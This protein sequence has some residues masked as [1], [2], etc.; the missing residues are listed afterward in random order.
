MASLLDLHWSELSDGTFSSAAASG[1]D[2]ETGGVAVSAVAEAM[3]REFVG[4]VSDCGA[5]S[6][7][8]HWDHGTSLVDVACLN[9]LVL[10][11]REHQAMV[12]FVSGRRQD[13]WIELHSFLDRRLS[14]LS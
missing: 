8:R 2:N 9:V 10:G 11:S 7:T 13:V 1:Q 14:W 4:K 3:L 12:G 5:F 6:A